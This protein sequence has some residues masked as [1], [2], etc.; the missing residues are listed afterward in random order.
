MFELPK[1]T[2][3]LNKVS[4]PIENHGKDYKLGVV[5]SVETTIPNSQLKEFAPGL[6]DSLYRMA[7]PE[8]GA[9]LASDASGPTALRY[10][11]MSPFDWDWTGT[12]YTTTIDYGL[13]GESDIVLTDS[14]VDKFTLQPMEGGSVV[15][16]FN[17]ICHPSHEHVG[18]LCAKQKQGLT[19]TL[20]A[21]P[22][23]TVHELFGED[24]PTQAEAEEAAEVD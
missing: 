19:I 4:T 24:A 22:P 20:T 9:D 14:K 5:L 21:P 8:E 23:Q 2:V 15:V 12:G 16:S 3:K 13:G 7:T 17:V 18:Y 1:Q 11:K 10:P 6:C